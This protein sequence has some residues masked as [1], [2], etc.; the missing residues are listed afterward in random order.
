MGAPSFDI[1]GLV[2]ADLRD[3]PWE[4]H[5]RIDTI[6]HLNITFDNVICQDCNNK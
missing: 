4:L 3:E 1:Q 6:Q 5:Q 2:T